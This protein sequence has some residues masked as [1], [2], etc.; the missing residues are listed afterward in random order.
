MKKNIGLRVRN[1]VRKYGTR[2]P[3]EICEKMGIDVK[4]IY[5][6]K[7]K[8]Y[9]RRYLGFSFIVINEELS[10]FLK[11]LVLIHEL[12][13]ITL[14]HCNKD[15]LLMK[16]YYFFFSNKLENEANLFLAEFLLNYTDFEDFYITE[17]EKK[18]LMKLAELKGRF[19]KKN[20]LLKLKESTI[21]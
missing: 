7:T 1:L 11:Y 4:F 18:I 15:L 21:E 2:N 13:H 3:Y 14:K 17:E 20:K 12:G 5:L 19:A 16:N 9:S 6:G 8:G 10:D